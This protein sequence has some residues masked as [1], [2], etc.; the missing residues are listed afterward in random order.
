MSEALVVREETAPALST[1]E[2]M[3][4]V[5]HIQ[6]V[7]KEAMREGEH[8]GKIPGCG[9]KPALMKSGAEKL[10]LTFR[11]DPRYT[12]EERHLDGGHIDVMVTCDIH[13]INTGRHLG[14]GIGSCST[15][16]SKYRYRTGER[17]CPQCG[18]GAIIK[19]KAEYGGGW[20][21]FKKKGGC[22]AKF[23]DGDPAIE[24]QDAGKVEN[25]DIAD[26]WNTVRK[27]AKKRAFVDATLTV[28]GASD[29]FTQ[30]VEEEP[31]AR[32]EPPH[33]FDNIQSDYIEPP[34]AQEPKKRTT[35]RKKAEPPPVE[36]TPPPREEE[37]DTPIGPDDVKEFWS[38]ARANTT[39]EEKARGI[40]SLICRILGIRMTSEMTRAQFNKAIATLKNKEL[41]ADWQ[42]IADKLPKQTE[43]F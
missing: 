38:V 30:D 36:E 42:E 31:V 11:L 17:K 24:G 7:M 3:A 12:I 25:L 27:M 10:A 37:E 41:P 6:A 33:H 21:C 16:E 32:Q 19:G 4:Q 1:Q 9:D 40:A 34:P 29:I 14:S 23:R 13:H 43:D 8:W 5:H 18:Q 22:G 26:T 15:L 2:V 28:T 35:T 39:S 20:L